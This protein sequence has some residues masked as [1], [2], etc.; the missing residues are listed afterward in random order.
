MTY[1]ETAINAAQEAGQ[2]LRDHFHQDKNVDEAQHHDLKLELDR[3]AQDLIFER[4]AAE[5]PDHALYGEEGL[6]GNQESEFQWIVDPI[7]GTVN[8]FYGI[9]HFCVSIAMR[10]G[11][12]IL[13]G[14]IY[15][16][17]T[18]ELW[19]AEKDGEVLLNGKP[20]KVSS[21]TKLEEAIV[22]IGCGK[23]EE[24]LKIGLERFRKA[25][26]RC[27]KMRMMG[28]A[29][30]G[31]AYTASG[32]LDA[33]VESRISLWDIAAGKLILEMAGGSCELVPN[34]ENPDIYA[35]KATNGLIPIDEVL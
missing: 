15:D 6:G 18:G 32:R 8:F 31:M 19:T 12:D 24:A 35:I 23:D 9:P 28:S 2:L 10:Q 34:A 21:R 13:V 20:L 22:F 25:S 5:F 33:Y 27:R 30:L 16:P 14:V 3:K 26:L 1:L 11:E 29:A 7:D 4:I 17:M